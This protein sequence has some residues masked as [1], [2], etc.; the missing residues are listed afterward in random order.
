MWLLSWSGFVPLPVSF[1]FKILSLEFVLAIFSKNEDVR[2]QPCERPVVSCRWTNLFTTNSSKK[3]NE[4][5][6]AEDSK[7]EEMIRF[8]SVMGFLQ[9]GKKMTWFSEISAWDRRFPFV[10]FSYLIRKG[11]RKRWPVWNAQ[12]RWKWD[13][14]LQ[15]SLFGAD[16]VSLFIGCA[17]RNLFSQ[18]FFPSLM[19][20]PPNP[21][22]P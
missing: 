4:I 3:W 16:G 11:R 9:V 5:P 15:W 18:T 21:G 14:M 22:I 20:L 17:E 13:F 8:K 2:K 6:K 7:T 19:Q 1:L 10:T 12:E